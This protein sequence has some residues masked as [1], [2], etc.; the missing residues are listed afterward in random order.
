MKCVDLEKA[1]KA[2][3]EESKRPKG[4]AND[5]REELDLTVIFIVRLLGR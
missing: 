3:G 4:M 5:D 1:C 2:L